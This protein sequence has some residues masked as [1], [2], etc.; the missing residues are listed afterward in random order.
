MKP[1]TL[2]ERLDPLNDYLF[3]RVMGEKG[4][5]VQ[6]LG[7]LNAVLGRTDNDR[8]VSVEIIDN[9][10]LTA[11]FIGGKTGVLDVRARLHDGSMVNIEVQLRNRGSFEKRSLFYWSREYNKGIGKGDDYIELP[12]VICVNIIDFELLETENFHA[13]FHLRED[14]ENL[15]LTNVL[16]IHFIDMVK[17]RRLG[18]KDVANDPMHRWLAYLD[19]TSPPELI[20]EVVGMDSAI[21]IAN[22]RQAYVSSD[23]ETRELYEMRQKAWWDWNSSINHAR[24]EGLKEGIEDVARK[25]KAMG[26]P[27][28]QINAATGLDPQAIE[29]L[30]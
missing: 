25:L 9:K 14:S 4:D 5:E 7:F 1:P 13:V 15:I 2:S 22:D 20:A 16:E 27:A 8:L 24:R 29:K 11:D 17:W 10:N 30:K 12:A 21:K 23:E 26:I 28:E 18:E 6:L 3:L 19:R